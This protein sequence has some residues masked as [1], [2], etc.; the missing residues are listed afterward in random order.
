MTITINNS[1]ANN[2]APRGTIIGVLAAY[3]ASGT[4]I[5]CTFTLTRNSAGF[6]AMAE[7]NL[8]TAFSVDFARHLFG[9]GPS[10]R[11]DNQIQRER[12]IQR[13]RYHTAAVATTTGTTA[14][15]S[16]HCGRRFK[17]RRD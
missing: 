11:P 10:T 6:F 16:D 8:V 7:S 3:D 4:V 2:N 5:P 9:A 14:G 17:R 1:T 12:H 15:T 13:W